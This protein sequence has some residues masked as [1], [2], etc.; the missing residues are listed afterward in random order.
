MTGRGWPVL[1]AFFSPLRLC[2]R[3]PTLG[4]GKERSQ[5]RPVSSLPPPYRPPVPV[6][7][8]LCLPT[9]GNAASRNESSLP[10]RPTLSTSSPCSSSMTG[11][12]GRSGPAQYTTRQRCV[13]PLSLTNTR[14]TTNQ[15]LM[16]RGK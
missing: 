2:H 11:R 5:K 9:S 13:R 12:T 15:S 4:F 3:H 1:F 8:R 10:W 14:G 7:M 16:V 6:L